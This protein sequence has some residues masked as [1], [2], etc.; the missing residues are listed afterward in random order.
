MDALFF[1]IK[2][3][4]LLNSSTIGSKWVGITQRT[5]SD[6]YIE[7]L[8]AKFNSEKG[9]TLN[10]KMFI[11]ESNDVF[12]LWVNGEVVGLLTINYELDTPEK[13]NRETLF[14]CYIGING[15]FILEKYR[16]HG[17]GFLFAETV[18]SFLSKNILFEILRFKNNTN[19]PE[20]DMTIH[21]DYES[22]EGESFVN[23]FTEGLCHEGYAIMRKSLGV[24]EK[25]S[26]DA[27]Y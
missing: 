21:A 15:V 16:D 6:K 27:G 23:M 20:L 5:I 26:L 10:K 17:L 12:E 9:V 13:D 24:K 1:K 3:S 25:L 11:E 7:T 22:S 2:P 14:S 4:M 8:V 19:I 18:S